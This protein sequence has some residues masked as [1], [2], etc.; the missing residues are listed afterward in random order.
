M[1]LTHTEIQRVKYRNMNKRYQV[2]L[3]STYSDLKE[4]RQKVMQTLMSMDCI[5]AG[6]ELFPAMDEE[7]FE[8][9]KKVIDD[10]DYYILIAGARYGSIDEHGISYTEKEYDY[11]IEK[12][13][14]VLAFLHADIQ[15][16]PASKFDGDTS[17]KEKLDV[18]RTKVQSN[19][20][21]KYWTNGDD[22]NGKVA[23]SLMQTI[24]TYPAIGW[25]RANMQTNLETLQE[26]NTLR[27]ELETLRSDKHLAEIDKNLLGEDITQR[28]IDLDTD[29][30]VEGHYRFYDYE[31]H[32]QI[33]G[34]WSSQVC[35]RYIWENLGISMVDGTLT[36]GSVKSKIGKIVYDKAN[37]DN[38]IAGQYI[39]IDNK[40][41]QK[42]KLY[43]RLSGLIRIENGDKQQI[44][45]LTDE[46]RV[47]ILRKLCLFKNDDIKNG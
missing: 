21:V 29:F 33:R 6:M 30:T 37:P 26:L 8:F 24:K 41:F 35:I 25:I 44:W 11:A 17:L 39:H 22:L 14:P 27:K 20:L 16:L 23:V 13:I 47:Y 4:E 2:F 9:I 7:Q 32:Q 10:C 34:N 45:S 43:F 5:P 1:N 40:I 42:I 18:F 28:L 19:R 12:G 46:G 15:S 36:D 31:V 38:E 3:S